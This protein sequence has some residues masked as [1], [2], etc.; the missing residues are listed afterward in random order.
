MCRLVHFFFPFYL[1]FINL[2]S[3][4]I[5]KAFLQSNA[6]LLA[7]L[8]PTKGVIQVSL[9]EPINFSDILAPGQIKVFFE[10]IFHRY[11]TFEFFIESPLSI[12]PD[13][14][15]WFIRARWSF[16]EKKNLQQQ[17]FRIYFQVK[18]ETKIKKRGLEWTIIE[19]RAEKI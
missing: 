11:S 7:S 12:S 4:N 14:Q 16:F 13:N 5:E 9:P 3:R 1:I 18:R 8:C 19:I 10:R 2:T 6:A 17:A 15:R